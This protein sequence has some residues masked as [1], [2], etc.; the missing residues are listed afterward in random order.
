MISASDIRKKCN[1]DIKKLQEIC[2]H[3]DSIWCEE[4]W[5]PAHSTGRQVRCCNF[6][7]KVLETK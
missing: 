7:E 5:A 1:E 4:Q 3:V 2:Q 6:C